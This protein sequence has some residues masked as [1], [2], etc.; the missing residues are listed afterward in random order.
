MLDSYSRI[1]EKNARDLQKEKERVEKL[2]LNIMPKAV[3]DELQ[4]FG[5]ATPAHFDQ[6]SVVMLDFVGFTDMAIS[7]DPSAI[8]S[9]LNDIFSAFDRV[10]ECRVRAHPHHR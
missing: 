7:S 10:V 5:T 9:E 8:V 2:L 1:A 4:Q 3:V 6:V